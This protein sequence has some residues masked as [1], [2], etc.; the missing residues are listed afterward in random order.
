M[1]DDLASLVGR[2]TSIADALSGDGLNAITGEVAYLGKRDALD[3]L[4][5]ELPGRKF[6]NWRPR[7]TV[8]YTQPTPGTAI[9]TP[10]PA[11]PWTV[12]NSGRWAGHRTPRRGRRRSVSW[13]PTRGRHTWDRAVTTIT[14]RTPA[15]VR[16]AVLHLFTGKP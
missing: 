3:L 7:M 15:R 11:G 4:D 16:H 2:L 12:L 14:E 5:A 6:R 9:I 1:P 10:Q 13:G 8:R